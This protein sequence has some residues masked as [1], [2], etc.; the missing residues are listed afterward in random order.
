MPYIPARTA[1]TLVSS[2]NYGP[3]ST[4]PK[5]LLSLASSVIFSKTQASRPY[6]TGLQ[7]LKSLAA[8][9]PEAGECEI[10]LEIG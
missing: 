7:G 3:Y 4:G 1:R 6:P 10:G 2:P 9:D 8:F 5:M